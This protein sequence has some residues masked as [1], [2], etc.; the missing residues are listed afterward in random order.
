MKASDK[1]KYEPYELKVFSEGV[2]EDILDRTP[3]E[4]RRPRPP[5]RTNTQPDP[6][7]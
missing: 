7:H 6:K 5:N 1:M 3:R 2:L 4:L